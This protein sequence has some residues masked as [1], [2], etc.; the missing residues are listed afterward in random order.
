MTDEFSYVV[1]S[2]IRQSSFNQSTNHFESAY[3]K[4]VVSKFKTDPDF[5]ALE[6]QILD[7]LLIEGAKQHGFTSNKVPAIVRIRR[8]KPL[9]RPDSLLMA[10]SAAKLRELLEREAVRPTAVTSV[11]GYKGRLLLYLFFLERVESIEQAMFMLDTRPPM[12]YADGAAFIAFQYKKLTCR[13]VLSEVG[14]LLWMQWLQMQGEAG[15]SARKSASF[16]IQQY[17]AVLPDW[18]YDTLGISKIKLLRK[19]DYTL[20]YS[21]IQFEIYSDYIQSQLLSERAFFRLLTDRH[22]PDGSVP[23]PVDDPMLTV[24]EQRAW[25]GMLGQSGYA[26]VAAQLAELKRIL[27]HLQPPPGMSATAQ[28]TNSRTEIVVF[29]SEWL[30]LNSR[31]S[32]P[33]LWFLVAW[34]RSLLKHGGRVKGSLKPGTIIDY[35]SSIGKAFL[36]IFNSYSLTQLDGVDW[37]ELLNRT[38]DDI[39]SPLRKGFVLYFAKFLHDTEL[40]PDLPVSELDV[41][42]SQGGVDANL[43]SVS[44]AEVILQ[45]LAKQ[46]DALANDAYLLFSLCF[47]SGLRRSEAA[48]LQLADLDF[49]VE[50]PVN[51]ERDYVDLHIR[52]NNKR[53][54]KSS[55]ANRCLQLDALWPADSITRLRERVTYLRARAAEPQS[56]IFASSARSEQ[57]FRLITDLM[58]HYTGDRTLRVH[59]LRHSF[60][61]WTW[62]RLN[63]S[64]LERGRQQFNFLHHDYFTAAALTYFYRRLG[65]PSYTRKRI[66]ILCHLLGH[67]EPATTI[68]SY[69]HLKDLMGYLAI[70]AEV[71]APQKLVAYTLGR[72][73]LTARQEPGESIAER[74]QYE[75]RS[76]ERNVAPL[77]SAAQ[78]HSSL[79]CVS[80]LAH[81]FNQTVQT[82]RQRTVLE[83]AAI[84]MVCKTCPPE[85]IAY[86]EG[87]N[88]ETVRELID[89]AAKVQQFCPGHGKRLPL[90]P[91]LAPWIP[92]LHDAGSIRAP[93]DQHQAVGRNNRP[94]SHSLSV[95]RYLFDQL[96]K[97]LD[98]AELTWDAV[99]KSCQIMK[100]LVPGKGY[101]IRCPSSK[102]LLIF[103]DLCRLLG[104][105]A[106]HIRLKLHLG[107]EQSA[108][109]RQRWSPLLAQTGIA[110]LEVE[111]GKPQD[112]PYLRKHDG[113]GVMEVR[114]VN[115]LLVS[116]VR[117]QRLFISMLQLMLIL[118]L[119][120]GSR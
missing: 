90:I 72:S 74:L 49:A 94:D 20:R 58:H 25:L 6:L 100:Y 104:L 45:R 41:A 98:S 26:S 10:N 32:V 18:H 22:V 99:R 111:L 11:A 84:L 105:K 27:S 1:K 109:I 106:R 59:H 60:A 17:L 38:T 110:D 54:L 68:G 103:L 85:L 76:L 91:D 81:C 5:Q 15:S 115:N 33:Y 93:S 101:L 96:Q 47:Y 70:G 19:I 51:G 9:I 118:S 30:A 52:R 80:S 73:S 114:L 29:F 119:S 50:E 108:D 79:A 117:R 8:D 92:R 57:A 83:W 112:N 56:L 67:E 61:N 24:R 3:L 62:F 82:V 2:A 66:Y 43:L 39:K 28:L 77:P 116:G 13:Y 55:A 87:L 53:G 4:R 63:P 40:V 36:G 95:L 16:F 14:V 69:L 23:E 97:R 31:N 21:P 37:V 44:H 7:A 71:V 35:V 86:Q 88:A 46:S 48:F 42:V 78:L 65:I 34:T 89:H 12:H 107:D 102:R 113:L 64:L 120:L 75:T